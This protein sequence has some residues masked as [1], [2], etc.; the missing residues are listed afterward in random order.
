VSIG[1]DCVFLLQHYVWYR[2]PSPSVSSASQQQQQQLH[3]Q[4][5]LLAT[6]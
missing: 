3:E 4:Q 6:E 1:F 5:R 2:H